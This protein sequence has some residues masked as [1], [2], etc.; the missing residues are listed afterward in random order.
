MFF[1]MVVFPFLL[2]CEAATSLFYVIG[3]YYSV[4]VTYTAMFNV[5]AS[6]E[7]APWNIMPRRGQ[8]NTTRQRFFHIQQNLHML[9]AHGPT[10]LWCTMDKYISYVS[11]M[12]TH[13][14]FCPY[15]FLQL[16][17]DFYMGI[18]RSRTY[19]I[20]SI[21]YSTMYLNRGWHIEG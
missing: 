9:W 5:I 3:S 17:R 14:C 13:F 18:W 21:I 16:S 8:C 20:F 15:E 19:C 4:P 12:H 2:L 1:T 6:T 7:M 11:R 10:S